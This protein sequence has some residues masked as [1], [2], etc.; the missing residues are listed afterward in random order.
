MM[1]FKNMITYR[2]QARKDLIIYQNFSNRAANVHRI[3]QF[4]DYWLLNGYI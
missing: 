1:M 3:Q 4:M 2:T